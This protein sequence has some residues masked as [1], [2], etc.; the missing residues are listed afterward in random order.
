MTCEMRNVVS[1]MECK[2]CNKEC[3]DKTGNYLRC[4]ITVFNQQ[5]RSEHLGICAQEM[6]PKFKISPYYK[7]YLD[8]TSSRRAKENYFIKL[9]K[10]QIKSGYL[11]RVIRILCGQTFIPT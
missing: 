3:I 7:M 8:R 5:I 4:R 1:V 10:T 6:N 11:I 2:G 9:V